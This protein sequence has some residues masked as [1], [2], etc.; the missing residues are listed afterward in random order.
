MKDFLL[1]YVSGRIGVQQD[2]MMGRARQ[3]V[4]LN[5]RVASRPINAGEKRPASSTHECYIS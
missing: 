1:P 2:C 5:D 3:V 4:Q